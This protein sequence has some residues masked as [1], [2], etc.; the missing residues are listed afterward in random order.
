MTLFCFVLEH[1]YATFP[2]ENIPAPHATFSNGRLD[3][4]EIR[5]QRKYLITF[6]GLPIHHSCCIGYWSGI[7]DTKIGQSKVTEHYER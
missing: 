5:A 4:A 1:C 7:G 3:P 2:V 6:Y